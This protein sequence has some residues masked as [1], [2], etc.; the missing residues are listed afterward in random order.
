MGYAEWY[1]RN[2]D[3]RNAL[4]REQYQ[5][6]PGYRDKV[7]EQTRKSR[8]KHKKEANPPCILP[9][10]DPVTRSPWKEM[11][12]EVKLKD[13]T[14]EERTVVTI[15]AVAQALGVSLPCL[16]LW[17][18]NGKIP[19]APYRSLK[20]DRL[21]PPA[22]VVKLYE[23]MKTK[24]GGIKKGRRP[25]MKSYGL[26]V[27]FKSGE[28]EVMLFSIRQLAES[29]GRTVSSLSYLLDKDLLPDTPLRHPKTNYRLY[30]KDMIDGVREGFQRIGEKN[31]GRSWAGLKPFVSAAWDDIG[32]DE[33]SAVC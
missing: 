5:S 15:G 19:K 6:D 30:T 9:S 23:E 16:R 21:Y 26:P 32:I 7:L 8:A 4:R 14:V 20:N 18:K 33:Q 11:T 22:M 2:G 28:R 25:R 31:N 10:D 12:V 27:K 17:E 1:A 29:C 3:K 24:N 13:G